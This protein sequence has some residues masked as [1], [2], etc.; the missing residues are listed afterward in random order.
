MRKKF[1]SDA[2]NWLWNTSTADNKIREVILEYKLIAQSN[3]VISK[4]NNISE[5]T[6]EW[7]DK[8]KYIRISY[9]AA[10]NYLTDI[11]ELLEILH[12][13]K[14]AGTILDSQK[15]KLYNLL[16]SNA[17]NFNDFYKNQVSLFKSVCEHYLHGLADEDI[18]SIYMSIPADSFTKGKAEY[19]K[20]VEA[21]VDEFKR[22]SK[23]TN[24]RKMWQEKTN[25]ETPREWSKKFKMPILCLIEDG[26]LQKAKAAFGVLNKRQS[27]NN[28]I[29]RAIDFISNADF[30]NRLSSE[31]D[32]DSAF[33]KSIIKNYAVMLTNIDEVKDYLSSRIDAEP[34][35]WFALPEV[36]K[37]LN[38]LAEAKYNQGGC[39]KAL[40]KIDNMDI[41]DVKRYLKDLIQDN[42]TVGMAIIE[43]D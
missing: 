15:Q 39:D 12:A 27:D 13:I 28:S 16:I 36:D 4:T 25:T 32:R 14:K 23:S 33:K 2:A 5:M 35:D 22:N 41:A 42:M 8:C 1:D 40:E 7:C 29:D 38:Q 37:K 26:D 18:N 19:L 9:D 31:T 24:L 30:F 21:K 10:K 11:A 34:Y 6:K 20:L 3:K 43:D 17:D